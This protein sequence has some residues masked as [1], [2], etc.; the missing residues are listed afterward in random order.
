MPKKFNFIITSYLIFYVLLIGTV[1]FDKK[2]DNELSIFLKNY[3]I[4]YNSDYSN[5]LTIIYLLSFFLTVFSAMAML[6]RIKYSQY[7][8]VTGTI[9]GYSSY[10]FEVD[11]IY[12]ST[13]TED[14]F[15]SLLIL[16][17]G[18]LVALIMCNDDIGFKKR[19]DEIS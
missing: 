7:I 4:I 16:C 9:I 5:I 15:E 1:S 10:I 14:L 13:I 3:D 11:T 2:F 19:A 18:A 8:F 12:I 6:F 17:E